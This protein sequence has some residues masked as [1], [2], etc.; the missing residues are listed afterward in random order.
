MLLV[1]KLEV[2][3]VIPE[4]D[5]ELECNFSKS[6]AETDTR[7]T[8]K[9]R[10]G[11]GITFAATWFLEVGTRRVKALRDKFLRLLPLSRII[12][13]HFDAYN[14]SFIFFQ[15]NAGNIDVLCH[16]ASA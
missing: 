8:Q 14:D 5:G 3:E 2:K 7:T 9:W 13:Y 6:F 16:T 12:L 4:G 1:H 15:V 10:K 11:V